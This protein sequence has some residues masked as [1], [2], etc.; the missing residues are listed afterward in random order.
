MNFVLRHAWW[1][2][3]LIAFAGFVSYYLIFVSVPTLR[4]SAALNLIIVAGG[5]I[6]AISGAAS[7]WGKSSWKVRTLH[8]FGRLGSF[9]FAGALF[10]YV[11]SLSYQMPSGSA[12]TEKWQLAPDFSLPSATGDTVSLS[13]FR[14]QKVILSFYRGFW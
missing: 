14:G 8:V 1:L 12:Q 11:F 4:D 10:W 13:S 3:P 7:R 6:L 5:A 2:A 9:L